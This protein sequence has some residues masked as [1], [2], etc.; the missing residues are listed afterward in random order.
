MILWPLLFI[1]ILYAQDRAMEK[2]CFSSPLHMER[3]ARQAM[4]IFVPSD[5]VDK[6]GSCLAVQMNPHRRELIQ[7][8]ILN[9][10]PDASV[11]YS[12]AELKREA[13]HLKVEK[14]KTTS[15][16]K[17]DLTLSGTPVAEVQEISQNTSDTFQISTI[18]DFELSV[19]QDSIRGECRYIT[20]E[21]YEISIEVIKQAKPLTPALQPGT[22]AIQNSN[23]SSIQ[24]TSFLKTVLQLTR[25]QKIDIGG[26]VKDLKNKNQS[27]N[28]D[29]EIKD[30]VI[31]Q[32]SQERVFLSL[33]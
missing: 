3:V 33:Q 26:I 10:S 8:F 11:S 7:K 4:I 9:L 18:K 15:G 12:T 16:D 30:S 19:D 21:T 27:A 6:E 14:I 22:V 20:P 5:T 29:P 2:Y 1:N 17:R 13:C 32:N 25:G 31:N 24:E 28:I 23:T